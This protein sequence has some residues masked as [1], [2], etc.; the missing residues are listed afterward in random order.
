MKAL[1]TGG[2]QGIGFGIAKALHTAGWEIAIAAEVA[3]ADLSE[4][5]G[6]SYHQC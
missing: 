4:L 2:Q 3:D 5:P 6:A 1:I